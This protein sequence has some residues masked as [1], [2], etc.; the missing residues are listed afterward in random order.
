MPRKTFEKKLKSLNKRVI[1]MFEKVL[2]RIENTIEATKNKSESAAQDV[3][4]GDDEIDKMEQQIEQMCIGIFALEQ[5]IASDLRV[6]TG[7]LKI[8]TDLERIADQCKDICEI[9][10]NEALFKDDISISKIIE[11]LEAMAVMFRKSIDV[12]KELSVDNA[13]SVCEYDDCI[14][15]L[16][17]DIILQSCKHIALNPKDVTHYVDYMFIAKY[18]ERIGDHC[19]NIAEWVIYIKTGRHSTLDEQDSKSEML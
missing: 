2:D 16:F 6:V 10:N 1:T 18:I 13:V 19:T 11:M 15:K 7:C 5:P 8:I 9:I 17:S 3:L 12:F 4:F 14:D